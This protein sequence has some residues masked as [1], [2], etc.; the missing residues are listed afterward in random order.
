MREGADRVDFSFCIPSTPSVV[1][2]LRAHRSASERWAGVQ[3]ALVR[4]AAGDG[5]RLSPVV[6]IEADGP[7]CLEGDPD[8]EPFLIFTLGDVPAGEGE[9]SPSQVRAL[10]GGVL[11]LDDDP[12]LE[13]VEALAGRLPEWC[14]LRHVALRPGFGRRVLRAICRMPSTRAAEFARGG[15]LSCAGR[16]MDQLASTV[17]GHSVVTNVNLDVLPE[18]GPRVGIEFHFVGTTADDPRW[19]KLFD[20]L[21]DQGLLGA[22]KRLA[23]EMWPTSRAERSRSGERLQG[24]VRDLLVKVDF[25]D[26]GAREAK[27]YLVVAPWDNVSAGSISA[28]H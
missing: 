27:A 17:W 5:H 6:W 4:W 15:R 12:L 9:R 14:E 20:A 23:F 19:S 24:N 21:Q 25:D 11:G 2:L 10:V 18:I 16:A 22:E 26:R 28:Q 1:Q 8:T 3:R 7:E 13:G